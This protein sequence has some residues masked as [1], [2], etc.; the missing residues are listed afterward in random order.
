MAPVISRS[1]S[2]AH[3]AL[4]AFLLLGALFSVTAGLRNGLLVAADFKIDLARL[5]LSGGDPYA[6]GAD[7]GHLAYV[8]L[9]PLAFVDEWIARLLWALVNLA[10]GVGAGFVTARAFH[11]DAAMRARLVLIL[12]ASTPFRVAVGNA[13]VS[14][15]LLLA[16]SLLL[17]PQTP[18]R[19]VAS[20]VAYFKWTFAA[21]LGL[22]V[23]AR[24]GLKDFSLWTVPALVGFAGYSAFTRSLSWDAL[25]APVLR[26]AD[27]P[28]GLMEWFGHGDLMTVLGI[29]GVSDNWNLGISA[30]ALIM[31]SILVAKAFRTERLAVAAACA[32]SLPIVFHL[33]YDYVFLLP[34]LAAGL[35]R[36]R[37]VAGRL[38]IGACTIEFFA[39]APARVLRIGGRFFDGA[40]P[41]DQQLARVLDL[42]SDFGDWPL[43]LPAA[44]VHFGLLV[45][46]LALLAALDRSAVDPRTECSA[47][48]QRN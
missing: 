6:A 48:Q 38:L 34:A 8:L 47:A 10:A 27:N 43:A 44:T 5:L 19:T 40:A 18:M 2:R 9:A 46:V 25:V 1:H 23:L 41:S 20:G 24:R 45:S 37:E 22:F 32:L 16:A 13:Q 14:L 30:G 21:P 15:I 29:L 26:R 31:L 33:P 12:L 3:S 39:D 17:L 42:L 4:D 11:L 35:E 28:N 7:Y 36:R